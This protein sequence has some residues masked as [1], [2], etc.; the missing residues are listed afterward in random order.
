MNKMGE[1][2]GDKEAT[3]LSASDGGDGGGGSGKRRGQH[4]RRRSPGPKWDRTF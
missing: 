1:K 4:L 2:H 3:S